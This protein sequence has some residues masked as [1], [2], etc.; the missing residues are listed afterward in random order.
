[1]R[2]F[3]VDDDI[4]IRTMLHHIIEDEELGTLAGEAADGAEVNSELLE[5]KKGRYFI[6]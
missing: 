1:M 5:L 2:F 3:I 6:N 4:S